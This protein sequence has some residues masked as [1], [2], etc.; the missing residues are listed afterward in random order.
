MEAL[1]DE[2]KARAIGISN[3]S[4]RQ[5]DSLLEFARVKPVSQLFE[6][7]VTRRLQKKTLSTNGKHV[8]TGPPLLPESNL[9]RQ[10]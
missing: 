9:Q 6:I 3:F 1:I 5:L 2:G 8:L 10:P 4:L 7:T